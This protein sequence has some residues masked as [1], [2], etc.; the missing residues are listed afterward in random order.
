[1]KYGSKFFVN[2]FPNPKIKFLLLYR[3]D[4]T[5]ILQFN[6]ELMQSP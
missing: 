2:T 3:F 6:I 4:D 5:K 1:M